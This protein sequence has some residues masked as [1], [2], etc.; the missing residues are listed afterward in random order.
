M[1][2]IISGCE[3]KVTD[4]DTGT[5]GK[6]KLSVQV[7]CLYNNRTRSHPM[8]DIILTFSLASSLSF[9][10]LYLTQKQQLPILIW[11]DD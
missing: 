6:L 7:R 5:N 1:K 4:H 8:R 2:G 10:A 3:L 9:N 11:I